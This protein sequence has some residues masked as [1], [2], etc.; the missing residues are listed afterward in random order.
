MFF[1]E[2]ALFAQ[3]LPAIFFEALLV[4]KFAIIIGL[5]RRLADQFF[6]AA[7]DT[8]PGHLWTLRLS[9]SLNRAD[10]SLPATNQCAAV[11]HIL[12][13]LIIVSEAV[14]AEFRLYQRIG[15]GKETRWR[16]ALQ[17]GSFQ[18]TSS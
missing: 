3:L 6:S 15:V 2:S 14:R 17:R 4:K 7:A 8:E 11:F 16:F 5:I 12:P 9:H 1:T 10:G 13:I 18:A